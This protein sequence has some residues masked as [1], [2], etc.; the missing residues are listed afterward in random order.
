MFDKHPPFQIDGNFGGAA[1]IAEMLVQSTLS[2]VVLL[3][4]LPKAWESG[5][6]EGL[7]IKGNSEIAVVWEDGELT[8]CKITAGSPLDTL[9]IYGKKDVRV[10]LGEGEGIVL[11]S[12]LV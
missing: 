1:G 7:R 3:P 4:A 9:V 8:S 2:R 11:G 5:S 12:G 10:R 6:V